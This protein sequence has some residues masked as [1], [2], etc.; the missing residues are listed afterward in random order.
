MQLSIEQTKAL[1]KIHKWHKSKSVEPLLLAGY[2]GTGKTTL[3][4]EFI[5]G[6]DIRPLC[7]APT[8]KAASVLAKRLTNATV[9]TVHKALYKPIAANERVLDELIAAFMANPENE[10]LKLAVDEEK[11]RLAEEG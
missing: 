8:G 2:A 10:A 6:L 3:L 7:C 5:N 11:K 1:T 9:S 4:Q